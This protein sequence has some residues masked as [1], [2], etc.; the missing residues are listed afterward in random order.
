ME[1]APIPSL[2]MPQAEGL[3]ELFV[4]ALDAPASTRKYNYEQATHLV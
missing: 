3:L 1:A 4:V 2:E